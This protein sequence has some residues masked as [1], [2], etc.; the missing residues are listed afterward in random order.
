MCP[1]IYFTIPYLFIIILNM[2]NSKQKKYNKYDN[3]LL[4]IYYKRKWKKIILA[5]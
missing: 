2:D 1:C 4:S 5:N 3:I